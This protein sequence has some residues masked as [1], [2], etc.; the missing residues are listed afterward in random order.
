MKLTEAL[1]L[2][3]QIQS[4]CCFCA[5]CLT[6]GSAVLNGTHP[7][8]YSF[9]LL[10]TRSLTSIWPPWAKGWCHDRQSSCKQW[11][12]QSNL[13]R[14]NSCLTSFRQQ[15]DLKVTQT[16]W[17]KAGGHVILYKC[18]MSC[19]ADCQRFVYKT[20]LTDCLNW[21]QISAVRFIKLCGEKETS[22]TIMTSYQAEILL[23]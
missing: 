1:F 7:K 20:T 16:I 14:A 6:P 9:D 21:M 19:T 11:K 13:S 15:T 5:C 17:P 22:T 18:P 3:G 12:S 23:Y 2:S 10:C 8:F 4:T